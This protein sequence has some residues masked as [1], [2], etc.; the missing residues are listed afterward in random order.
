MRDRRSERTHVRDPCPPVEYNRISNHG[1]FEKEAREALQRQT[2]NWAS[3]KRSLLKMLQTLKFR[4]I[5]GCGWLYNHLNN[6]LDCKLA[7]QPSDQFWKFSTQNVRLIELIG[8]LLE[9]DSEVHWVNLSTLNRL[10]SSAP[11]AAGAIYA[12]EKDCSGNEPFK[13]MI[14]DNW[15]SQ[16]RT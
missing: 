1:V 13:S 5:V 4:T 12:S 16:I 3:F 15:K 10:V 14:I 9:M 11:S 2:S 6:I 8:G 7:I